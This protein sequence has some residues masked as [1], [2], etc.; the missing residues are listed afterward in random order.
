MMDEQISEQASYIMKNLRVDKGVNLLLDKNR[1]F[2]Q[3]G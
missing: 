2:F 3:N 1:P